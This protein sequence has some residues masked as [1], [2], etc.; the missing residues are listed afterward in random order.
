M[1]G[2]METGRYGPMNMAGARLFGMSMK[3][4]AERGCSAP[5][6]LHEWS[7]WMSVCYILST[8]A[9]KCLI[10]L[11]VAV[12]C[13]Q[14]FYSVLSSF[15]CV[16]SLVDDFFLHLLGVTVVDWVASFLTEELLRLFDF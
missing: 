14:S 11:F 7:R 9:I 10:F 3:Q 1:L 13:L 16:A 5:S 8:A 6:P 2:N 4:C 12:S 15:C